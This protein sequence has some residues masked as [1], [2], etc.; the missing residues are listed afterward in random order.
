[1]DKLWAIKMLFLWRWRFG[2]WAWDAFGVAWELGKP[3]SSGG[4]Q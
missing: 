2:Y 1:M 3:K 4:T